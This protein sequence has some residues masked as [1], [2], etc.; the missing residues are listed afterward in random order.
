MTS[1]L[2][3]FRPAEK[4]RVKQHSKLW[5]KFRAAAI[6]TYFCVLVKKRLRKYILKRKEKCLNHGK[7]SVQ[8]ASFLM[9]TYYYD[10][11]EQ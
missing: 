6:A 10:L 11:L 8:Q 2:V 9:Q 5:K 4:S 1:S 7:T 3:S